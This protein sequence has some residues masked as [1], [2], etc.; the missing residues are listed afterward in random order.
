MSEKAKHKYAYHIVPCPNYDLESMESWLES[1]AKEGHILSEHGFFMNIGVFYRSEP[2][3]MRFRLD[4]KPSGK[5]FWADNG[6]EPDKEAMELNAEFGW[7]Y[8]TSR[9]SFYIYA[10]EDKD[11]LELNT[12]PKVQSISIDMVRKNE[13]SNLITIIFWCLVYPLIMSPRTALIASIYMGT[14]FYLFTLLL[15]ISSPIRAVWKVAYLRKLRKRTADGI[16]PDHGKDWR[17]KA[18]YNRIRPFVSAALLIIWVCLFLNGWSNDIS[19]KNVIPLESYTDDIPFA[20][21]EKLIP[22]S[23]FEYTDYGYS[24]TIELRSDPLAPTVVYLDQTG[25]IMLDG[26]CIIEGGL[27]VDYYETIAPTLAMELAHEHQRDDKHDYKKYYTLLETPELDVDYA[28]A[29][30]ALFPTVIIVDGNK[31]AHITFYSF[32]G[33]HDFDIAKLAQ[34]IVQSIKAQ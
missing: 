30:K 34:I 25:K 11:T 19:D 1:M 24:N 23:D 18:A 29:Y 27:S 31:I 32:S 4:A 8:I 16:A 20:T 17:K 21:M 6:G 10:S 9:G 14:W 2:K 22:G 28:V 33:D 26:Q 13:Q 15:L 3:D 12:D 7:K 5:G